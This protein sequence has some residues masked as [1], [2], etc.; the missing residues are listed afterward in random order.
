MFKSSTE[1][2][3]NTASSVN[4]GDYIKEI[5]PSHLQSSFLQVLSNDSNLPEELSIQLKKYLGSKS[6]EA[7]DFSDSVVNQEFFNVLQKAYLYSLER[8]KFSSWS[9]TQGLIIGQLSIIIISMLLIKFFIFSN[10]SDKETTSSLKSTELNN[11]DAY[12]VNRI[13]KRGGKDYDETTSTAN[14]EV[15]ENDSDDTPKI[16]SILDKTYYN[17]STHKAESLDWFNVLIAQTIQQ[18]REEAWN[19]NNILNSLNEFI[20]N[21]ST[22]LPDYLDTLNITELDIGDDFPIFSNCRIQNEKKKLEAKIDIDLNDRLA[23]GVETRLLLNYPKPSFAALPIKLTVAV[24]RFQG[25]LTVSLTKADEFVK[26]NAAKNQTTNEQI[27]EDNDEDD[28][29]YLMFSFS[30]EYNMEFETTSLIGA[31]SKLE[32]IP[33]IASVIEYQIKKWFVERCVEP[34]FQ[35]V[36]LPSIW[37]RSK[38]TRQEKSELSVEK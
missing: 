12:L 4:L 27:I 24:V 8:P 16:R 17:V 1:I 36:R 20:T 38:N 23:I 3:N 6:V 34:R 37:P 30:P 13:L 18:F 22:T 11:S 14:L 2:V 15:E 35:F 5:L 32:N 9:F 10:D 28:G 33:K 21:H 31:R 29:Y 26:T 19:K 7:K 25:C